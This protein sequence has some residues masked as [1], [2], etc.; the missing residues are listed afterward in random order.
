MNNNRQDS[1]SDL[2]KKK[3]TPD[4]KNKKQKSRGD[5]LSSGGGLPGNAISIERRTFDGANASN[6]N[7]RVTGGGG[8]VEDVSD[9]QINAA[10]ADAGI[11]GRQLRN[12]NYSSSGGNKQQILQQ[13]QQ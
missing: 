5:Q 7:R 9:F 6:H 2:L 3:Q 4:Q 12:T 10:Y 11:V 8:V 1:K 13:Q